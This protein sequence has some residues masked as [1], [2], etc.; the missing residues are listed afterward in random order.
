MLQSKLGLIVILTGNDLLGSVVCF[1]VVIGYW[2]DTFDLYYMLYYTT[3]ILILKEI[4]S[5]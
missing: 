2:K 5:Q 1:C 3:F 4:V